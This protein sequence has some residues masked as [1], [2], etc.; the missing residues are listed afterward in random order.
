MYRTSFA[1]ALVVLF[2]LSVTAAPSERQLSNGKKAFVH[3]A[4][5]H[6]LD[7][8]AAPRLGPHL[9]GI[10]GRK[11]GTVSG[12]EYSPALLNRG[13]IWSER[14]LDKFITRPRHAVNGTNMP[15]RGMLSPHARED[16]IAFLKLT[17]TRK[18]TSIFNDDITKALNS[19][20][21]IQGGVLAER[22][23]VCHKINH[24]GKHGIGPN[25]IGVVGRKAASAPGFD[26]SERLMKRGDFWNAETLN[27]FIFEVKQFDQGSHAAFYNLRRIEDRADIIAWLKT[28]Q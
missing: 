3:C 13:G 9:Y 4:N 27:S 19:G 5:C 23:L 1:F 6:S 10:V 28:L 25:L 7:P 8:D 24:D 12:F 2:S 18:P 17:S 11:V 21:A 16:L 26:Y 14:E 15:Y 20:D 22:C